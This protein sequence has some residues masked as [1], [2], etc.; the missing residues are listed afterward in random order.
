MSRH[1]RT[2]IL[3]RDHPQESQQTLPRRSKGRVRGFAGHAGS[4]QLQ[5]CTAQQQ[6]PRLHVPL[7]QWAVDGTWAKC[8]GS[9]APVVDEELRAQRGEMPGPRLHSR[10]LSSQAR[11]WPRVSQPA[12]LSAWLLARK[13]VVLRNRC[14]KNTQSLHPVTSTQDR[15]VSALGAL[16]C[17]DAQGEVRPPTSKALRQPS[18]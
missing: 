9:P 17:Q 11:G 15:P 5:N 2:D 3:R 10:E 6:Q 14:A 18:L 7:A 16:P 12:L 8:G 13:G 4:T 1:P